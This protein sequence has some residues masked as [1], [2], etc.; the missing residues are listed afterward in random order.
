M[1]ATTSV[2]ED[3]VN[4]L[5]GLDAKQSLSKVASTL[6]E[7]DSEKLKARGLRRINFKRHNYF[8]LYYIGLDDIVY[9]TNIFHGLEDYESKLT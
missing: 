3:T 4:L 7:P 8:L 6:A 1:P 2:Y 5:K 9:I